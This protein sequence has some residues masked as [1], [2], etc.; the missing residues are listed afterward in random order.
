MIWVHNIFIIKLLFANSSDN[1]SWLSELFKFI[2]YK[3]FKFNFIEIQ[4][5]GR[6]K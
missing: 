2:K 1:V 4:V 3:Q 5:L 6:S